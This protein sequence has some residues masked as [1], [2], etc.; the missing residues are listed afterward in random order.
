MLNMKNDLV[1]I[2]QTFLGSFIGWFFIYLWIKSLVL[3]GE[4]IVS[5][6]VSERVLWGTLALSLLTTIMSLE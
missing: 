4:F 2:V 3:I 6:G 1:D 5:G